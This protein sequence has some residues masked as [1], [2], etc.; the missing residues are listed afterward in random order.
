VK[1]PL[2]ARASDDPAHQ[3]DGQAISTL[4]VFWLWTTVA[5]LLAFGSVQACDDCGSGGDAV[6]VALAVVSWAFA[7]AFV[8]ALARRL[9]LRISATLFAAQ[10]VPAVA[11]YEA[12]GTGSGRVQ[13]SGV[14]VVIGLLAEA[15][16]VYAAAR[17]YEVGRT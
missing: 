10:F 13:V 11:A 15:A 5:P 2:L 6:F 3:R 8:F 9:A 14:F 7:T 4:S 1:A 17:T 12:A 16:G